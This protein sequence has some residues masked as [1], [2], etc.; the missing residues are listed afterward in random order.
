[1][2]EVIGLS[3][4]V[5]LRK[6]RPYRSKGAP[7]VVHGPASSCNTDSADGLAINGQWQ[8][9]AKQKKFR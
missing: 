8:A 1:V 5:G 9:P 6:N 2:G 7:I 4:L 3:L